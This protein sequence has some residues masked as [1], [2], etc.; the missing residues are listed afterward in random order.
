MSLRNKF[1]T[2]YG[3]IVKTKNNKVMLIKRKVPY[4][5]QNFYV[6]LHDL[7]VRH[8]FYDHN[9][10]HRLKR[11]FESQWL[12]KLS[13]YDQ[14]DYFRYQN[15]EVFEDMYD[16][17]HGQMTSKISKDRYQC[18]WNA[19]REFR[20]E[21]GFRFSYTKNDIDRYPL[22]NVE[23]EGC[24]QHVYTQHFFIVENVK[25]LC[26]H[27]YFDSFHQ[28][29]VSTIKIKNWKDDRLVYKSQLISI[30]EAFKI[31]KE[32]QSIKTDY[33]H[34][35]LQNTKYISKRNSSC[36]RH[37]FNNWR[38]SICRELNVD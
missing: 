38:C 23:F 2:S 27:R 20:E 5:V 13:E 19:F 22:V 33:K 9:P 14:K 15:G 37:K 3:L 16:F 4:C 12:P 29:Y 36:Y 21:T 10:F 30:N 25:D 17:P 18:F 32:Q 24:D 7:G 28:P 26:R 35:L 1:T 8:D 11:F 34:L 6:L 31:F